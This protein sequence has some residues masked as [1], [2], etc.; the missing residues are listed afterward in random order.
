[1]F[2]KRHREIVGTRAQLA[3]RLRYIALLLKGVPE[4]EPSARL[5]ARRRAGAPG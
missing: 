4:I 2:T 5:V 1:M 3:R